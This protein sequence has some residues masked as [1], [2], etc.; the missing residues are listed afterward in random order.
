MC[1]RAVRGLRPTAAAA[2][3]LADAGTATGSLGAA[4]AVVAAWPG[5]RLVVLSPTAVVHVVGIV[6]LADMSRGAISVVVD[7]F[8]AD[9]LVVARVGVAVGVLG[10][11]TLSA[12]R[13]SH[14]GVDRS[15]FAGLAVEAA[16]GAVA[17]WPT[18]P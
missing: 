5:Q 1:T 7:P 4:L 11:E 2:A 17:T 6:A 9:N 10:M 18:T 13:P 16:G 3:A 15:V 14:L 8:I 12:N